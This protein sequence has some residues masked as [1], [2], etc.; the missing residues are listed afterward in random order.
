[1]QKCS[2]DQWSGR[3]LGIIRWD[4]SVCKSN[5]WLHVD[6]LWFAFIK[7][8][9]ILWIPLKWSVIFLQ[10]WTSPGYFSNSNGSFV[11]NCRFSP[12]I[13]RGLCWGVGSSLAWA[14]PPKSVTMWASMSY[15]RLRRIWD[16]CAVESP[17]IHALNGWD[18]TYRLQASWDLVWTG[19]WLS[20]R[21][22]NYEPSLPT[23]R[24]VLIRFVWLK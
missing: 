19:P 21:Q 24:N 22:V 18:C 7:M 1:M 12:I 3:F 15:L 11:S 14:S 9:Y 13:T 8:G 10:S 5:Q 23:I 2:R 4:P 17:N 20:T 6:I 16:P